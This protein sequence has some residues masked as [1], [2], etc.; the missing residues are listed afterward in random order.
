MIKVKG[1]Q[2]LRLAIENVVK[3][4]GGAKVGWFQN[5]K[6]ANGTSIAQVAVINEYGGIVNNSA[7]P[8]RPFMRT[9][10]QNHNKEWGAIIA[11]VL[12]RGDYSNTK[13]ALE[14]GSIRASSDIQDSILNGNW[15]PNAPLTVKIK[16]FNRPLIDT[17]IMLKTVTYEINNE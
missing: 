15:I 3:V 16:G 9:A 17:S 2:Q 11:N 8:A 5:A 10:F 1:G 4:R 6:Y 7:I 14:I 13:Q 12:K